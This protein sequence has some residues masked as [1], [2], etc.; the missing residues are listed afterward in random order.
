MNNS[1]QT[2]N[3]VNTQV[4]AENI[5]IYYGRCHYEYFNF[6]DFQYKQFIFC[7]I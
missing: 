1:E 3:K 7:K 5:S 2:I 6:V 4:Y